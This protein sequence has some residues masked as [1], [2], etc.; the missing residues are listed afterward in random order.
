M[1]TSDTITELTKAITAMRTQLHPVQKSGRNDFHRYSYAKLEDYIATISPALI[2]NKLSIVTSVAEVTMLAPRPSKGDKMENVALVKIAMRLIHTSGEWLEVESFGEGQDPADKS[3]YK[4]IT[5]AR[6][7]GIASMLGL[8]TT[9]DPEA[10]GASITHHPLKKNPA[11]P[12]H[13]KQPMP[14][15]RLINSANNTKPLAEYVEMIDGCKTIDE[16]KNVYK[17]IYKYVQLSGDKALLQGLNAAK[18]NRKSK[19]TTGVAV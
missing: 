12:Q 18:E 2:E 13:D 10:G 3:I 15:P 11:Y 1:N 16:L 4:A 9:D 19:L 7:Y 6:K 17:D 14:P 8:A 5:G